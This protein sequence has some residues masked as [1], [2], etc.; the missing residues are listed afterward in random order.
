MLAACQRPAAARGGV[1]L[2]D[3]FRAYG[4]SYRRNHPLPVSHLKV[5]EAV[6][7]CRTAVLGG[8]LER[9]DSCGFERPAYNSCRNRH[10]PKC[11]S[12]AKLK[13]L[14]K[15][16]SEILPVGYF[17]LVFTLPHELNGLILTNKKIL[18]SHLFKA[19]G[20]TLVEFRKISR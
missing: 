13:W 10:C 17:H 20:E 2:A 19:V 5:I 3:I 18:L 6:E 14:D 7:R 4:E 16:K 1:E 8:H 15:Q 9:C 11:Q 12:L